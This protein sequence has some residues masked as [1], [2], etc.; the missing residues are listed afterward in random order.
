M[1]RFFVLPLCISNNKVEIVGKQVH[2]IREVLRLKNGDQIIVLDNTGWEYKVRLA[3]ITRQKVVGEVIS[4]AHCQNEPSLEVT[5]FQAL[6][7]GSK[8]DL[9]LQKCTEIGVARFVPIACERCVAAKPSASRIERWENIVLEAA[10]Q[11]GRGNIPE[12]GSVLDFKQACENT[13][14]FSLIPWELEKNQGIK[15][16]LSCIGS[17]KHINIFIGPEGGFT[18]AEVE[19]AHIKGI[20]PVSLGKRIMR[21]E[22]AGLVAATAV[23]YECGEMD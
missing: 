2:Q 14:G 11:S 8:T 6:L 10:E 13:N 16:V 12:L 21:A 5:V 23:F 1:H 15:A 17:A 18:P 19:F 20:T 22:T 3:A 4:Q 7:K 9:V